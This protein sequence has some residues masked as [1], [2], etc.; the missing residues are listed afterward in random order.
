MA[1]FSY[2]EADNYGG[3]GGHGFLSIPNDGDVVRV[4]FLYNKLEDIEGVA[5]HQI[6]V[7]GKKR[8]VNCLREYGKPVDDCPMCK[9]GRFVNAKLFIPVYDI[10]SGTVKIWERGKK[11]FGKMAGLCSRYAS[12][13]NLVSHV[14]EIERHGKKG[15]TQTTYEVYE[16]EKDDTTLEDLPEA[17]DIIGGLVLDKNKEEMQY[18]ID[19]DEFPGAENNNN[20]RSS[21]EEMPVRRRRTPATSDEDTF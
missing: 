4:R 20:R 15:D 13:D 11:F 21:S 1:R 14:F 17:P 3:N 16:C 7:D 19:Y 18:F 12:K 9:A 6:E 2:E 10:E 8:Y 5:V